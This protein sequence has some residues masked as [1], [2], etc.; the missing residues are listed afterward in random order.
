MATQ[1]GLRTPDQSAPTSESFVGSVYVAARCRR[2]T[3]DVRLGIAFLY[4]LL[5]FT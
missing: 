2:H 1:D 3:R 5:Q 4:V